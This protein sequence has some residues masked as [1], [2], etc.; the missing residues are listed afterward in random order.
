MNPR[1]FAGPTGAG[2]GISLDE[3]VGVESGNFMSRDTY[4]TSYRINN[5]IDTKYT[6]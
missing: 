5:L 4:V 1:L 6:R 3:L 2:S